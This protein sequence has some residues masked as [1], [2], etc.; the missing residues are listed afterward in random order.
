MI[1]KK[2][3]AFSGLCACALAAVLACTA[4]AAEVRL[5]DAD[6]NGSLDAADARYVLRT[7]VELESPTPALRAVCDA[8]GNGTV[9]A[10]DAR[11]VLRAVVGL[12]PL[13]NRTFTL[14]EAD[15]PLTAD[16]LGEDFFGEGTYRN[17]D[18]EAYTYDD[19][20]T[21]EQRRVNAELIYYY[22]SN[23]LG[24]SRN[25]I[26]AVL[27]NMEQESCLS[28]GIHQTGGTGYGLVQ[29]TPGSKY[30]SWASKCGYADDSM[31]GQLIFLD[32]TMR[33]DC[34]MDIKHWFPVSGY[35]ETYSAFIHS[36]KDVEYLTKVFEYAYEKAGVPMMN[37]RI[38]Y[39]NK[40]L[41]HF[42]G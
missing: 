35:Y 38:A 20:L 36:D 10:G 42:G 30:T 31:E 1:G 22:L 12:D 40:W 27:G 16:P 28:P 4:A 14:S 32:L 13:A 23:E 2:R 3:T 6:C 33:P 15:L 5:G 18:A 7:A 41:A 11:S 39:A 9:D 8:D 26:C 24:W 21:E 34:S 37:K 17:I 19:F 29:W 25:A